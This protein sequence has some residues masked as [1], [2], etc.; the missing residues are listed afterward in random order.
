M[1]VNANIFR[2]YDIR[3]VVE[4]DLAGEVPELIGRAYGSELRRIRQ[5]ASRLTVALGRDNRPSSN[6][7]AEG[8]A[9]GLR[10]AG[11]DVID[12]G[13]VPTP[14][15]YHAAI[16]LETDGGIQI[17]GSHNPPEYNGFKMVVGG[18][19]LYGEAI[20]RL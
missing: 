3:G 4:R 2:E 17:T 10:A 11:I 12:V 9:R 16:K 7:L 20:Q 19:A 8:V 6:G 18:R 15:L 5:G 14:V 13:T 1:R